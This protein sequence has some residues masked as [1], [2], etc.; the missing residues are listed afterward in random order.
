MNY[1]FITGSSKGLGKFLTELLL[2]DENNIVYGIAR[3]SSIEHERYIHSN[4]DLSKLNDVTL[5]KFPIFE[6]AEKIVLVNNAGMVGDV[7][8]VGNIDN[9]Q[10]IDC[11]NLNLIAP[12][13]LTNNFISK[14]ANLS[15]NK[16][17]LNISSGAGRTPI[18][19]W[20]VYCSTKAGLDMFSQVLKEEV[21]IDDSNIK[22]LSLAPGIIDTDMQVQIRA[23]EESAFS[24]IEKFIE[25]KK[26]GDLTPANITAQ[27]VLR[28]IKE[29]GLSTNVICSVRD[30]TK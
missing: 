2:E 1:F 26:D 10:I 19:G 7:K 13:I 4:I 16:M 23:A 15:C 9:Q 8:H 3:S 17:V 12:V 18:D 6:N 11:Y 30:L 5:Y 22:V 28:F 25:Y 27:Q 20:N 24:N 14:Y 21:E 29:E